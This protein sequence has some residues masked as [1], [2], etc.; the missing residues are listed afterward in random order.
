MVARGSDSVVNC[1]TSQLSFTTFEESTFSFLIRK[2]KIK[3][4]TRVVLNIL[5]GWFY[6]E[7]A[8]HVLLNCCVA[9]LVWQKVCNWCKIPVGR[10]GNINELLNSHLILNLSKFKT[11]VLQ[12]IIVATCWE[13]WRAR[14]ALIFSGERARIEKI[15]GDLQLVSFTWVKNR[16]KRHNMEWR[17]WISFN[18]NE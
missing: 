14:N 8:D 2:I 11:K 7:D 10:F 13:I 3:Y 16:G 9:T 6:K 15:F 18:I 1:F 17:N 12:T 5:Q 4:F